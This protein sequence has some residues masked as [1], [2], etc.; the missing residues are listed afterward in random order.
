MIQILLFPIDLLVI[1]IIELMKSYSYI[2]MKSETFFKKK[3][4]RTCLIVAQM[5][6]TSSTNIISQLPLGLL[7]GLNA[8]LVKRVF[9]QPEQCGSGRRVNG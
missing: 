8:R 3:Y 6:Y 9:I 7:I 1:K 4:L 2:I 5:V